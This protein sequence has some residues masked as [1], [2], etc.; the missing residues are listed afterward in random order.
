MKKFLFAF[1]ALIA[2][3]SFAIP[4]NAFTTDVMD[5]KIGNYKIKMQLTVHDYSN[6]I[7]GWYYYKSKGP[8]NKIQLSG[9]G[10]LEEEDGVTLTEKVN[11]KVTGTFRGTLWTGYMN[12]VHTFGY[13]GTWT[14]PTGK[15]LEFD[16]T[17]L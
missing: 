15:T 3:V 12:P 5:G 4:A 17:N 6:K 14:S 11:G 16:L 7:T 13:F 2:A 8:K 10:N 9:Y 1:I